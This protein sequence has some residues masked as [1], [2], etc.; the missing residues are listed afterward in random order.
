[1]FTDKTP[2]LNVTGSH[3][4]A[5]LDL[6]RVINVPESEGAVPLGHR[7]PGP[8]PSGWFNALP[9]EWGWIGE[10][11][12]ARPGWAAHPAIGDASGEA[13]GQRAGA[14]VR[15]SQPWAGAS[16]HPAP[17]LFWPL[18]FFHQCL[19]FPP[20]VKAM[21]WQYR[22]FC[23]E[24]FWDNLKIPIREKCLHTITIFTQ[25][26]PPRCVTSLISWNHKTSFPTKEP[27]LSCLLFLLH[28]AG[29]RFSGDFHQSSGD[30]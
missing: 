12:R 11:C 28:S 1:M 10:V 17:A 26:S 8:E 2:A 7:L 23:A 3:P 9:W 22:F 21:L 29:W 15:A 14:R 16:P 4:G 30:R 18:L 13:R 24:V 27:L 5:W 19:P 25:S 6:G 20:S